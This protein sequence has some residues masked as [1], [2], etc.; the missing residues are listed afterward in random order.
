MSY[1]ISS[2]SDT[3]SLPDNVDLQMLRKAQMYLKRRERHQ[4][5]SAME[6]HSWDLFYD[7]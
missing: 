2:E 5:P 4:M 3:R 1:H 7:A 6:S